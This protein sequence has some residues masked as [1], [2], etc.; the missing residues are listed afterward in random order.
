MEWDREKEGRVI[1]IGVR[2]ESGV[3]DVEGE[4]KVGWESGRESE[5]DSKGVRKGTETEIVVD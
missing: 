4:S 2:W 1:G 5:V 3:E